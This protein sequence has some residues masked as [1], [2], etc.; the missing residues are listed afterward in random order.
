MISR[1]FTNS[2]LYLI[3]QRK[4]QEHKAKEKNEEFR[5][6]YVVFIDKQYINQAIHFN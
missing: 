4:V 1:R 3:L 2:L 5:Y 6:F